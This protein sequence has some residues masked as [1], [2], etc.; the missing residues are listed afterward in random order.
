MTSKTLKS[1]RGFPKKLASWNIG[2]RRVRKILTAERQ[3]GFS[4]RATGIYSDDVDVLVHEGNLLVRV[5][6]STNYKKPEFYIQPSKA[7]RYKNNLTKYPPSVQKIMIVSYDKNLEKVGG[8]Q[9]FEQHGI[10]VK[11]IGYQD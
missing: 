9:Y 10:E 3:A 2:M 7:N 8:K 11:V 6:E 5:Y 4:A 1:T